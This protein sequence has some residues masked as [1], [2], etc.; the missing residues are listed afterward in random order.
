LLELGAAMFVNRFSRLVFLSRA[1]YRQ[2]QAEPA[3]TVGQGVVYTRTSTGRRLRQLTPAQRVGASPVLHP[4]TR[5][6]PLW[7]RRLWI[8]MATDLILD[9]HSFPGECRLRLLSRW[10]ARHLLGTDEI[11]SPP[12]W[13]IWLRAALV[14]RASGSASTS[15]LRA[16]WSRWPTTG[17]TPGQLDH[18]RSPPGA[19]R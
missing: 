11:H 1:L 7:Y 2:T 13:L 8:V 10:P 12:S 9:C 16:P 3:A 15:P 4:S 6:S 5:S 14:A 17:P 18:D 19:L